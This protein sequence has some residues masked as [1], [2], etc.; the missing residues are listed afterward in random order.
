MKHFLHRNITVLSALM[1]MISMGHAT[2]QA[3]S[4]AADGNSNAPLFDNLGLLHHPITTV[5][6]RAQQYF[7]QGLRLIYAF[8]H[9]EAIRSFEEAI[10]IDPDAAMAYWGMA[11]ALGPNINATMDRDQERRAFEAIQKATTKTAAAT[12]R[13]RAYIEALSVRYSIAPDADRHALDRAYADRMRQLYRDD[14]A[15]ADAATM[16]AEALMNVR[17]WDYWTHDGRPRPDTMEIVGTLEET[18]QRNPDHIGACHYYIHAVESWQPARALP[19]AD[20]LP[21]LAPGAGHLVHMP[22]HIY[23]RVGRYDKAVE[24]NTHAVSADQHYFEGSHVSGI[25][26]AGY[27]PHNIHFLC[28]AL[29][30]QGRSAEALKAARDL[31]R[32]VSIEAVHQAPE[33][34]FYIPI[35]WLAL[36]RFGQWDDMLREPSPFADLIYSRALWHYARGLAF[37]AKGQ[38]GQAEV[39]RRQLDEIASTMPAERIVG[40]NSAAILLRIASQVLSG[41]TAAKNGLPDQAIIHFQ[42]AVQLQDALRYSE[43][44]DWYYPVR[45]SLGRLLLSAGHAG[46]AE[47]VF[48]EALTR[49]PESPWSLDGLANSLRAQQKAGDAAPIEDRFRKAWTAADIDFKPSRFEAFLALDGMSADMQ[50]DHHR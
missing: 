39:E 31:T 4:H 10:R 48:R 16:F 22:S 46:K 21:S 18:L 28:A 14:P 33:M 25:Y 3:P 9:E 29:M 27:Y 32:T 45:E 17:P 24:R 40:L 36:V 41:Q 35:P 38:P 49:T 12:S 15:D 5:H 20:R 50:K 19:C 8:N 7:D 37:V 23:I 13:E 26:T 44:P 6:P 43:P 34:E 2:P 42:E 47:R 11:Y 1:V 30:M